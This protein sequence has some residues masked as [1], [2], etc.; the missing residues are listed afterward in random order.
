MGLVFQTVFILYLLFGVTTAKNHYKKN[1]IDL[2]DNMDILLS[3]INF[4][5][6]I[7]FWGIFLSKIILSKENN[8]TLT[9]VF[10]DIEKQVKEDRKKSIDGFIEEKNKIF[11]KSNKKT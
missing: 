3:F 2:N 6:I 8:L 4:Y 9:S 5:S 11:Q 7:F 10:K 1:K